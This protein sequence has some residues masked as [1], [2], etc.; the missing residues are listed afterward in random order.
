MFVKLKVM[1]LPTHKPPPINMV[2]FLQHVELDLNSYK[3]SIPEHNI[4]L[5]SNVIRKKRA[6][7]IGNLRNRRLRHEHNVISKNSNPPETMA[8]TSMPHA[9]STAK[10]F[11]YICVVVCT[12]IGFKWNSAAVFLKHIL[13]RNSQLA[14]L[15]IR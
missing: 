5:N 4:R 14:I 6:A 7:K 9:K 2:L 10:C 15:A 13:T 1:V 11:D 3:A 8:F 12:T